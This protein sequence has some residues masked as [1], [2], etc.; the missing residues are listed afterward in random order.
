MKLMKYLK[1][2]VFAA[3]LV[4]A[5]SCQEE[6]YS[7]G[8]P[9][10]LDC[11]GFYFPVQEALS[12][13]Q[14]LLDSKDK[15]SV[16]ITAVRDNDWE[17]AYV[18][19]NVKVSHEGIFE[20]EEFIYFDEGQKDAKFVINFPN[21]ETGVLY[22]CSISVTDPLY[23]SQYTLQSFE[24]SFSV[25]IANWRSLGQGVWR[26][27]MLC[28]AFQS[29][30]KYAETTCDVYEREDKPGYYRLD[31]VYTP[32]YVAYMMDG[33]L[34]S[35]ASWKEYSWESSIY[36]DATNAEKPYI[37]ASYIGIVMG[38]YGDAYIFSDVD[39][40]L[41]PGYS[42]GRYMTL[43]NGVF[44]A[45]A[46]GICLGLAQYGYLYSNA[47]R[48][49]MFV[50]PGAEPVDYTIGLTCGESVDGKMPI[51]FEVGETVAK[52]RYAVFEGRVGQADMVAKL[53]YVKNG[54]GSDIKS[55]VKEIGKEISGEY[56]FEFPKTSFYTIVACTYDATG[57]YQDYATA[58]FGYDTATDKRAIKLTSGLIVSE[59]H[60]A[61]GKTSEN[62]MEFYVY[63]ENINEA[64]VALYKTS[65]LNDFTESIHYEMESYIEPLGIAQ[66]DSLNR[67]GYFGVISGL[68]PGTDYTL[69]VYA[70]N[71]YHADIFET[72]ASTTGT[73]SYLEA[74]YNIY[75]LPAR[76]Q[77]ATHDDYFGKWELWS[78][79]PFK[80]TRER[81]NRGTVTFADEKDQVN[82]NESTGETYT[83][84]Y[85]SIAG[86]YPEIEKKYGI[87]ATID[88]EFYEGF[89]YTL[90]TP[91]TPVDYRA[92]GSSMET[93]IYPTNAYLFYDYTQNML[94]AG[95]GN[96]A[97]VGGFLDEN[98]EIIA[99]VGN[100]AVNSGMYMAMILCYFN[101]SSYSGTGALMEEEG[102][103]YPLLIKPGSEITK[104]SAASGNTLP[105]AKKVSSLLQ[106]ARTNY[107]ETERG[108]IM[109]TIDKV[110][111]R[112]YNYMQNSEQL[113]VKL[114][115]RTV[116]FSVTKT[117]T[118][119][120]AVAAPFTLN[121]PESFIRKNVM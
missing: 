68:S 2:I 92:P 100:P 55:L 77:P 11:H 5:A 25:M 65:N 84:D 83:T 45:P 69:L 24:V 74:D 90:M 6:P 106:T 94:A 85:M 12:G 93:T 56:E 81:F 91:I 18:P 114:D 67:G 70:D 8:E 19:V 23:V 120:A 29:A 21:A 36:I 34:N 115:S 95:L 7:P 22:E 54:T 51:S 38:N 17:E 86:M 39:E 71:G 89:A 104:K 30:N 3:T 16:T 31:N 28:A 119:T 4:V 80:G 61:S 110:I 53:D 41:G 78:L 111:A 82:K 9:D 103:A 37:A 117:E 75:D 40:N 42:N 13:G 52:V 98:K 50:L 15:K 109:S 46:Q 102:H 64:R 121:D 48:K 76:L 60:A 96:G 10:S 62:S 73:F 1:Y 66:L 26:D 118:H 58:Q 72:S 108:Y 20:M 43:K 33:S 105:A 57:K 99:F 101:S 63:G 87:D 49:F 14:L 35:L 47:N 59:K 112:P 107:V 97:M 88:L 32:E 79:D 113:Q 27:D 116:E 44:T